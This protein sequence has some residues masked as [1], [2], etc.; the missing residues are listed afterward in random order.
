MPEYCSCGAQL[1]PDARFCHKCGKPQGTIIVAEEPPEAS[2]PPETPSAAPPAGPP[3][4][5]DPAAVRVGLGMASVA[6]LLSSLPFLNPVFLFVWCV[7][8]GFFAAY[9]YRRRTG[10][11]LTIGGGL[12][13]GWITGILMFVIM[14]VLFTATIV[15]IAISRGG[16]GS[17]FEQQLR[18][19]MQAGDPNLQE[20]LRV[21]QSP[22]GVASMLV[23]AL[24]LL[25]LLITLL[26]TVGGAL[27][28][29][30]TGRTD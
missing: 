23:M 25:F 15:P 10:R 14:T 16:L 26:A 22:A 19:S 24:F 29:K 13:L 8:A 18:S 21:A 17:W 7:G 27:G 20:V 3:S 9:L 5:H 4:F 2:P 11:F 30:V 28:A 6:A 12:R 1:P